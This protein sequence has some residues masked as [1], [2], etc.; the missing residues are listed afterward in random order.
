MSR[1]VKSQAS[2]DPPAC[3]TF[4]ARSF[5]RDPVTHFVS[6]INCTLSNCPSTVVPGIPQCVLPKVMFFGAIYK[7]DANRRLHLCEMMTREV[8]D[9][10]CFEGVFGPSLDLLIDHASI[11]VLDRFYDISSLESHRVDPLLLKG[12]VL[13]STPSFGTLFFLLTHK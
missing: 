11:I 12:K 2:T 3:Q 1:S 8:S 7:S 10:G 4:I 9:F 6:P 5:S 13:V